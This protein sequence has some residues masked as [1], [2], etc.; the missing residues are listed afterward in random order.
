MK[1][2]CFYLF[3][4]FLSIC[5]IFWIA[6]MATAFTFSV[7]ASGTGISTIGYHFSDFSCGGVIRSGGITVTPGTPWPVINN[8]FSIE[9]KLDPNFEMT[10][11]GTFEEDSRHASGTW[12]AVSNGTQCSG[13]WSALR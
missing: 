1:K 3:I 10:V 4:L 13:S 12:Q 5:F 11:T 6:T 7:N 2:F 8:Q 9:N